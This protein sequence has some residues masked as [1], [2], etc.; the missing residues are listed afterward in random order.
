MDAHLSYVFGGTRVVVSAVDLYNSDDVGLDAVG[1]S[2]AWP[3]VDGLQSQRLW[4]DVVQLS[5]V[6]T[7]TNFSFH[8]AYVMTLQEAFRPT[9]H[10]KQLVPCKVSKFDFQPE[11]SI[12][13][14]CFLEANV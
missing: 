9:Y 2:S 4:T 14:S 5:G 8:G 12:P 13:Y 1:A 7:P 3:T 11:L 10:T 6:A